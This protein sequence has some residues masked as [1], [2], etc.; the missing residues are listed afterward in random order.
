[1]SE[2]TNDRLH[3][4]PFISIVPIAYLVELGYVARPTCHVTREPSRKN[5]NSTDDTKHTHS[6]FSHNNGSDGP[7]V[8]AIHLFNPRLVGDVAS[9]LYCQEYFRRL[10]VTILI[11]SF[12]FPCFHSWS[13]V[14]LISSPGMKSK[15]LGG[16]SSNP[17]SDFGNELFI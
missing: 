2:L 8:T 5:R 7:F 11:S 12:C 16:F 9:L 13:Q 10:S 15:V 4:V 14:L 6:I 1:V 3:A 17:S